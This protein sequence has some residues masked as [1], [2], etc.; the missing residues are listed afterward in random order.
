MSVNSSSAVVVA[1]WSEE[2]IRKLDGSTFSWLYLLPFN[3]ASVSC[4]TVLLLLYPL[5]CLTRVRK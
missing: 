4:C 1:E 5:A 2:L 3:S